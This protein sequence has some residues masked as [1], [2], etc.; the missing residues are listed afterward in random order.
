MPGAQ[1]MPQA[2]LTHFDGTG[3]AQL[4]PPPAQSRWWLHAVG[5]LLIAAGLSALALSLLASLAME[6]VVGWAFVIAGLSQLLYAFG[7]KGWGGFA[8]QI[9]IGA[10]FLLGGLTLLTNP[11][12]GLISLT[13]VIIATFIAS[14][15]LKILIGF[16]LRPMNGWGWFVVLGILSLAVGLLIWNQLPTSAAWGL[17]LLVGIDFLST[18]L[19]FLRFGYLAG[20]TSHMAGAAA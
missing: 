2:G 6:A 5:I 17:G 3:G 16:R 1:A 10:I 13:L 18:G 9:L 4:S 7:A 12:A 11:V 19:V 15:V 8:W 14:G 20:Q